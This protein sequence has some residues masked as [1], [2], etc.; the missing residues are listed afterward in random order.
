MRVSGKCRGIPAVLSLLVV[1]ALFL[2]TDHAPFKWLVAQKMEGML[3]RWS[4]AMQEHDYTIVYQ[5]GQ[6][7]NGNGHPLSRKSAE[8]CHSCHGC[9]LSP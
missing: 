1:V 5:N 7:Q 6:L 9:H 8:I 4:L 3:S 2:V